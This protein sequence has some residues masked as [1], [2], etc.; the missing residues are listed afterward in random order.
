[1]RIVIAFLKMAVPA[2]V[3]VIMACSE[4]MPLDDAKGKVPAFIAPGG[5]AR[6]TRTASF[7]IRTA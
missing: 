3:V 1:M 2:V 7:T 6:G 5:V 4:E